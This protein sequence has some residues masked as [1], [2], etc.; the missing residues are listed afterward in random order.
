MDKAKEFQKNIYYCFINYTKAFDYVD[1]N[2]RWKI[3]IRDG[4]TKPSYLSP[5]NLYAGQ[6]TTVRSRKGTIN[7][8]KI[9]KG[10]R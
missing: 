9:W 6:E 5:G 8:F 4:K 2:K 3:L 1:H 10:V 7:W